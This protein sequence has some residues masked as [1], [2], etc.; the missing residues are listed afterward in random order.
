MQ[1]LLRRL[2]GKSYPAYHDLDTDLNRG[3]VNSQKGFTLYCERAQSDPF[4]PP[5]RF[6]VVVDAARAG[7]PRQSYSNRVRSVA[8]GDFLLRDLYHTCKRLGA[9]SSMNGGGGGWSGPKGGDIQ[10]L[11]PS[12][13]VLEQSAV[14]VDPSTGNI[15][16][17]I[18]VNL[19]AR[20]RSILG[21]AAETIFGQTIPTMVERLCYV[22]LSADQLRRHVETVE[23]QVW[24]REQL[25]SRNIVAFVRNGAILPRKS[26]A[27]D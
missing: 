24:M 27:D 18:T 11:E 16:A 9:D 15:I 8:L 12:Q 13:H 17:Q 3:W 22:S 4:A 1:N 5:T 7:F 21:H 26:G 2:D 10:V 14:R 25:E 20:G 19:P 23:D 6:R